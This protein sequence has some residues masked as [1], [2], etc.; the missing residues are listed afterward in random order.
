MLKG[1]TWNEHSTAPR[2]GQPG[3]MNNPRESGMWKGGRQSKFPWV[4][5][6]PRRIASLQVRGKGIRK[7]KNI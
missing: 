1:V 5:G 4:D 2:F 7:I 3:I 6:R